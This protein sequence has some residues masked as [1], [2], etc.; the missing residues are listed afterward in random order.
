MKY[1]NLYNTHKTEC[2]E[3]N[4]FLLKAMSM[5]KQSANN[6][7]IEYAEIDELDKQREKLFKEKIKLE[8]EIVTI[9]DENHI[10]HK[11]PSFYDKETDADGVRTHN[12]T[13]ILDEDE[14]NFR[15]D[16]LK[17]TEEVN[18]LDHKEVR[19]LNKVKRLENIVENTNLI[20]R[21]IE[22]HGSIYLS[23]L[24]NFIVEPKHETSD[25]VIMNEIDNLCHNASEIRN[26]DAAEKYEL[27]VKDM[28]QLRKETDKEV[29]KKFFGIN[30]ARPRM[31]RKRTM[32]GSGN[33]KI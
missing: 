33:P 21:Y 10:P 27:I 23:Q 25:K 26:K 30:D 28:D 16:N 14:E 29:A 8:R 18:E 4:A 32:V 22:N 7:Q 5:L 31:N 9:E 20:M 1:E 13:D 3:L 12:G 19:M 2:E 15:E 6:I 11:H 24:D 17:W